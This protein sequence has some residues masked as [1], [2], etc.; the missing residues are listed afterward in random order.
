[1]TEPARTGLWVTLLGAL[2]SALHQH[3][4]PNVSQAQLPARCRQ[5]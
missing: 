5:R 4:C 3:L 2:V 1:M